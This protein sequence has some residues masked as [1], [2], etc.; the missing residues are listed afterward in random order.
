MTIRRRLNLSFLAILIFFAANEAIYLWGARLR[1]RTMQTLDNS[2]RREVLIGSIRQEIDNLHKQVT[3]LSEIPFN[4]AQTKIDPLAHKYFEDRINQAGGD[5][6]QLRQLSESS[7]RGAADEV[8]DLYKKLSATWL[9]FY[10]YLGTDRALALANQIRGDRQSKQLQLRDLPKLEAAEKDRVQ[11]A[12]AA[13]RSAS[14]IANRVTISLFA[15]SFLLAAFIAYLLSRYLL[16]GLNELKRGA[17]MIGGMQLDQRI[18]LDYRDELGE[19]A[20][21]FNTMR[22]NLDRELSLARQIQRD[23]LPEAPPALPGYDIAVLNEPCYQ[24]GGDYYDFLWVDPERLLLVVADVEGKGMAS[25]LVMSNVEATLHALISQKLPVEQ[26]ARAVNNLVLESTRGGKYLSMF[27]GQLRPRTRELSYVN[28]GHVPPLLIRKNGDVSKLEEGGTVVGLFAEAEYQWGSCHLCPGDILVCCTDG[29]VECMDCG[30][31]Q[32]GTER[33]I[34]GID[35]YQDLPA[36]EIVKSVAEE[37]RA[38]SRGGEL[39]DDKVLIVT[40]VL[41]NGSLA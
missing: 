6:D 31:E 39:V 4:T 34:E 19:L 2:R 32:Y 23:L 15:F 24:V 36:C 11:K 38:F 10:D 8:A 22:A 18:D 7:Y 20:E 41:A 27:I 16:R 9:A 25:A 17:V 35:R 13:F 33:L 28:A 40:K 29:V 30:S 37:L 1:A 5:I 21:A 3:L 14:Q 12:E 26:I